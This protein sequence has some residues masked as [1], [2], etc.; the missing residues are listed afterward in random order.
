VKADIQ[1]P[2]FQYSKPEQWSAFSDEL[3]RRLRSQP[4]MSDC[5]VA[6]PLPLNA[7]GFANLPFEL[8]GQA[9]LP[10]GIPETAHFVSIGGEYF[11]VMGIPL[12]RGRA[13]D[14][15][16]V[17]SAPRV[18]IIS[19]A[20]V[21]RFFPN[22]DP[23]GKQLLF[24]FP[25]NPAVPRQIV[26][27]V[28]DIRDASIAQDPGPMMYVPFDQAPI[29][30]VEV[31]VRS[32]LRPAS[33]AAAIRQKSHEID[34]DLPVTDFS[35]MASSI[36]TS[37]AQ[38]RFRAW[39][40]GSFAALALVLA[41]AGIFGVIS[42]SVS[43]RT[44]EI[45]IRIALG[46]SAANVTRL[47]LGESARLVLIGLAVG[48][49]IALGLGRFLASLLFGIRASDAATFLAVGFLLFAVATLA[50]YA[51]AR[52]ATHADPMTALRHE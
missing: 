36:D 22:Q 12:L 10:K 18:T 52:R 31:V 50:A 21:H 26:G 9:P 13:F 37:V 44:H 46:A 25:P 29:W 3:L 33:L 11:H 48:V 42:Y 43:R 51:P 41:A 20:F 14:E 38:P 24:S 6:V 2:R 16:D 34:K 7:Q 32:N 30:G 49:P 15:H 45:G 28:G 19:E 23:L 8:L 39:L 4:G 35:S 47:I 5:A 1:L 40:I 27:I 17:A